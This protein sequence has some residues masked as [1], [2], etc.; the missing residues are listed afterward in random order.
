MRKLNLFLYFLLLITTTTLLA[1]RN[2]SFY[3]ANYLATSSKDIVPHSDSQA[4]TYDQIMNLLD[5]IE[6][7]EIEKKCSAIQLEQINQ[8]L[9][10]LAT[11][12]ILPED[13]EEEL[14]IKE[15]VEELLEHRENPL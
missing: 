14:S 6:R 4:L 12:G 15:D 5:D 8:F 2:Q 3:F 13:Q 11:E 7:G 1:L 10:F 9:A